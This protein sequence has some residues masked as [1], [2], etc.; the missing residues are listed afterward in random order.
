L[1]L[2]GFIVALC[3]AVVIC[4][5]GIVFE[6]LFGPKSPE[7]GVNTLELFGVRSGRDLGRG[8]FADCGVFPLTEDSRFETAE[9]A[10]LNQ[11]FALVAVRS[12]RAADAV[13]VMSTIW[14]EMCELTP[15]GLA[16]FFVIRSSVYD[17][18]QDQGRGIQTLQRE[19]VF[20]KFGE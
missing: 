2:I 14:N 7:F 12:C 4:T 8:P 15:T 17:R 6:S 11:S 16:M 13:R 3:I 18:P 20:I 1:L 9:A 19:K 5:V 10:Y